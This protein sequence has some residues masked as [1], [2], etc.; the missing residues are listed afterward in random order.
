MDVNF[1]IHFP[2]LDRIFGTRHM[3]DGQWPKGYGVPGH[4]VPR[5]Y[6]AQFLYPFRRERVAATPPIVAAH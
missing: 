5:G 4:P 2:F 1:A 3:P 6:L